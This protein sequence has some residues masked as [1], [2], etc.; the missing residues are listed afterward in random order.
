[1]SRIFL[2]VLLQ[3][4]CQFHTNCCMVLQGG[5]YILI[6]VDHYGVIFPILVL[7]TFQILGWA[8]VYGRL[9]YK[10]LNIKLVN[11]FF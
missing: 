5:M 2:F 11:Y 10:Q 9:I 8:W 7:G 1:M 6:L 3:L 4:C